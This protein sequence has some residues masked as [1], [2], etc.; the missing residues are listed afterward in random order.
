MEHRLLRFFEALRSEG[1]PVSP[2]ETIDALRAIG[3]V[4]IERST[5]REALAAC[6]VKRAE[7]LPVFH[8]LFDR[9]FPRPPKKGTRGQRPAG[10]SDGVGIH[11]GKAQESFR[12]RVVRELETKSQE[13]AHPRRLFR[14]QAHRNGQGAEEE[15]QASAVPHR[16]EGER[17]SWMEQPFRT[18]HVQELRELGPELERLARFFARRL[19]GRRA[20]SRRGRLDFRRTFR[21]SVAQ[22]GALCRLAWHQPRPRHTDLV[23]LCDLSHSVA[24]ASFFFLCLVSAARSAF[25]RSS[26]F[27]FVD[28]PVEIEF[29]AHS[30]YPAGKLDLAARSD[31]GRVFRSLLSRHAVFTRNTLL[32]I[33]GDARTNRRPPGREWL[34]EIAR[35]CRGVVWLNPEPE[36]LWNTGDS[37]VG[38]YARHCQLVLAAS[39]ARELTRALER[40][41]RRF[42]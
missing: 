31:Y 40:A 7:D 36:S 13:A 41:L 5:L 42:T 10:T 27:G 4:G 20:A 30:V 35:Q 24:A 19:G 38:L 25:R 2:A 6:V 18:M 22:G 26:L 32:L 37:V 33:L 15:T 34:A 29:V 14:Y 3:Q 17:A 21:W 9:F 1:L 23:A 16:H 28:E 12:G 11:R 39:N 8:S